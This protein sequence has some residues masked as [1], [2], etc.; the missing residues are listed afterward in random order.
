MSRDPTLVAASQASEA[1]ASL[2]RRALGESHIT[3]EPV[4]LLADA[5]KLAIEAE[6]LSD[7]RAQ[8]LGAVI[9]YLE[10]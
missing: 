4:E 7:E 6:A 1:V 8:L 10:G 2:T 9:K 3:D 5:L